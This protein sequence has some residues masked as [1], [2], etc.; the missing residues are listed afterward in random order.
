M[1]DDLAIVPI[2]AGAS[3]PIPCEVVVRVDA[4]ALHGWLAARFRESLPGV[5]VTASH[6]PPAQRNLRG[7][8]VAVQPS[9]LDT[10]EQ[11]RR[12]APR[13][14]S[15]PQ[16]IVFRYADVL[17]VARRLGAIPSADLYLVEWAP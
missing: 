11:L 4:E 7:P 1:T 14:E 17:A 6:E 12:D 3:S 10:L 2:S 8:H 15:S 16:R 9:A 5:T 13:I